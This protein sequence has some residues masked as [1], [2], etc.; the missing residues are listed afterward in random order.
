M[1][2]APKITL[3]I[4]YIRVNPFKL[5]LVVLKFQGSVGLLESVW[6]DRG[7]RRGEGFMI[8]L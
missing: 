6:W 4:C 1:G 3:P 7:E 8:E 2:Q 5:F